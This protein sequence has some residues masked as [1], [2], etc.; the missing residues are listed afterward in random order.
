MA[1]GLLSILFAAASRNLSRVHLFDLPTA[2]LLHSEVVT[3]DPIFAAAE[4]EKTSGVL[5][6]TTRGAVLDI[7][8]NP[9]TASGVIKTMLLCTMCR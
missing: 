7:A 8:V 2:T 1:Y 9:A 4:E 6:V 3:Q 5:G